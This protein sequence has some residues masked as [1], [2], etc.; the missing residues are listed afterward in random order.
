MSEPETAYIWRD[1]HDTDMY[2]IGVLARSSLEPH[3]VEKVRC[4][5]GQLE[6]LFGCA[7]IAALRRLQP[8]GEPVKIHITME[9]DA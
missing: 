6:D 4:Y 8:G 3:V 7:I 5:E 1:K 9:L 2:S